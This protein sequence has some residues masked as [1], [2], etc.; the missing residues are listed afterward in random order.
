MLRRRWSSCSI[1]YLDGNSF[2]FSYL[3]PPR[4]ILSLQIRA[5]KLYRHIVSRTSVPPFRGVAR[6]SQAECIYLF[7]FLTF[8]GPFRPIAVCTITRHASLTN[9][10]FS[11]SLIPRTFRFYLIRSHHRCFVCPLG[12]IRSS[13]QIETLVTILSFV[14]CTAQLLPILMVVNLFPIGDFYNIYLFLGA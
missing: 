1:I 6:R 2:Y 9:V 3:Y 14:S 7:I 4:C 12:L 5:N 8:S 13:F 10:S 11:P